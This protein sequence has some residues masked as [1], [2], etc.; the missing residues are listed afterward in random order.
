MT[1]WMST[2]TTKCKLVEYISSLLKYM[3]VVK[4]L[5]LVKT[6]HNWTME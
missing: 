1:G 6:Q 3:K 4:L 2:N 5:D